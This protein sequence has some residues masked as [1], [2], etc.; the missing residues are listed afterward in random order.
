MGGARRKTITIK[1]RRYSNRLSKTIIVLEHLLVTEVLHH[2]TPVRLVRTS[3]FVRDLVGTD[4][5]VL[6]LAQIFICMRMLRKPLTH[7]H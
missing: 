5:E 1:M 3:P 6:T 4:H 2:K 7:A